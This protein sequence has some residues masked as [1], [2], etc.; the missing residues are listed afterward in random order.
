M[1]PQRL[2]TFVISA[3]EMFLLTYL[4]TVGTKAVVQERDQAATSHA[5][6]TVMTH[7]VAEYQCLQL[8]PNHQ[9]MYH[10]QTASSTQSSS[11]TK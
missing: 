3:L 11:V 2:V 4:L 8:I 6:P 5:R 7:T 1:G 9:V 10:V